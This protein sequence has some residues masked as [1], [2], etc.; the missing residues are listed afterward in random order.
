MRVRTGYSFKTAVGHAEDAVG[1]IK[2]IGWEVA[3]I[4]DRMSTF[5]FATW[6]KLAEKSGLRPVYG[7]ELPVVADRS[8]KRPATDWWTFYAKD[9]LRDLHQAIELATDQDNLLYEQALRLPLIKVTGERTLM[10]HVK[11]VPDL[12]VSLAPSTPK[13]LYEVAK[14]KGLRF[15]ASSDNFYTRADDREFYRI[16]LGLRA[17]TQSYPQH[18]LSDDEWSRAIWY[19]TPEEK[20]AAIR[21]R[22][23]VLSQSTAKLTRAKLLTPEKKKTLRQLCEEGARALNVN[24]RD[25]VY[26]ERLDK[27][28][29]MIAEKEFEDYFFIIADL[30]QFSRSKMIV[31]PARGSSCGSLVC[32]LLGITSVDPIPYDLIFERFIDRTRADLPDIDLDFSDARRHL[33]IEYVAKK[34]G[35]RHVARLGSVTQ[36]QAKSALK[37]IGVGLRIPSW[38]INEV[39]NTVI[40]RSMGDSRASSTV[41][42]TLTE[43]D[44]GRKLLEE[45]PDARVAGR[46]EA[47]PSGSGQ[48][49]AGVILT[50]DDVIDFVAVDRRTG[51]AMCDKYDAEVLN[52]LKID[53][54]GLTQLSTFERV[55]ELIGRS[56]ERSSFFEKIPLD[57]PEAFRVLNE[58]RFSGVFQFVPDSQLANLVRR[59]RKDFRGEISHVEDLIAFTALVRPGPMGSGMTD[60]WIKRRSGVEQVEYEHPLLEPYLKNTLGLVVYQEQIMQIGREIGDL[61]WDDVTALRKAMSKSLGKEYFD[62]FG[63]RWKAG[64]TKRGMPKDLADRFWDKMCQFGMW[65]FNRSHSVAYGLISYWCCWL[66]AYYPVEFA[67][68]TL[69]AESDVMRQVSALREMRDVGVDY[70]PFD[71]DV[72]TDRWEIGEREDGS[73]YLVGPLSNIYGIGPAATNA[74]LDARLASRRKDGDRELEREKFRSLL[75]PAVL[76]KLEN[77]QTKLTTLTPIADAISALVPDLQAVGIVTPPRSIEDCSGGDCGV[78][79]LAR[80][81]KVQPVNE[82]EPARIA[83]RKMYGQQEFIEGPADALNMFFEDD[84]GE[85]FCKINHRRFLEIGKDVVAQAKVGKSLYAIKGD[86][87]KDFRMIRV[88]QIKYLGEMAS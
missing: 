38:Q 81:S 12:Y 2:E 84:T 56:K 31:G 45:Y 52:L 55:L 53:M 75:K 39:T 59:M 8:E 7:V 69:D 72:S 44:V 67:A 64:A 49:A 3:P 15:V 25:A 13:G 9:R 26:R 76:K 42:D 19:A 16:A 23:A 78:V 27:E 70:V 47:H 73:R 63:D 60:V 48:H 71:V 22:D 58:M 62:Q 86:V 24:L 77:A 79:I 33:A 29:A 87:P 30:M 46:M 41:I 65:S 1:R 61:S 57:D 37:M 80:V 85:I 21:L 11:K 40:K 82:N 5:G 68:A 17:Q 28:L 32:Y 18:I 88:T 74:V 51:V 35:E 10:D 34:Y 36:W 4:S 43:T 54:L 50:Q 66:K 6:T 14:R 83:R 20:R